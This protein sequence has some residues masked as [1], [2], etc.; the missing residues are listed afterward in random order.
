MNELKC[1]SCLIGCSGFISREWFLMA[2]TQ[3]HTQISQTYLF[4]NTCDLIHITDSL[5]I[6]ARLHN[7]ANLMVQTNRN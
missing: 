6:A 4:R 2:G 3:A 7:I 5:Y 1:S